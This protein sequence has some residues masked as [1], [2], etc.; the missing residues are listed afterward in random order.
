M[1]AVA[2]EIRAHTATAFKTPHKFTQFCNN[3]GQ[4]LA[5]IIGDQ[6]VPGSMNA[7]FQ[8]V[9][10][11]SQEVL[12][13]VCEMGEA[14]VDLA[15]ETATR[16]F[17]GNGGRGWKDFD[18][19]ER[20]E[21]VNKLLELC[22]RD[23]DVLVACEIRDGGKI[24]ALAESDF[25]QIR[26]CA[27][28]FIGVARRIAL[29]DGPTKRL[30]NNVRAFTY[31]EPWGVVA[32]IIPWNYPIVLT[33]WFMFPALLAGN[34]ILIKPAEDTPLS[35]LYIGKLAKEA[36][37]PP[38]VINVLPGR[39]EITGQC[40]AEHP[41]IRFISFTGSPGVGQAILRT[42]DAHGTRMKREMGGN[43]AAIVLDDAD[44]ERVARLIGRYTNQHYGQTCCTIHRVFVANKIADDFIEAERAF[45]EGLKIGYQ[46]D[47]GTQLGAVINST[48][49]Q[50]ILHA[51]QETVARG[52][53]PILAGGVAKVSGKN[54]HYLKPALFRTRP[55]VD[56]NPQEVFHTFATVCPV[57]SAEEAL[58][59]ANS[60]PYGLGASVW[61]RDIERGIALA[62]QFRDGTCQ[63]NRHNSTAYGLP[64]GGQGISGGPGAGVN[65]EDTFRDYTQLKAV[66]VADYPD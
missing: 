18:V 3:G 51:Q 22:D 1:A 32:G 7:T 47:E 56:C 66:Y 19:E 43:G 28:Y 65:C 48:Q 9:D 52:G 29:G 20:I 36:G 42:C 13:S 27:E 2:T 4:P 50:R 5:G 58:R 33:S 14:E 35:A 23:R 11:G 53:Q 10:P 64:Y 40:I 45:F 38:G 59:L 60:S 41:G 17:H 49:R 12:A 8:T 30:A 63:V 26:E 57:S 16:A 44:P 62:K 15:V 46:A 54:G 6:S 24:S 25:T 34:T 55:G 31:R 21:L 37:F 61:T 39:G